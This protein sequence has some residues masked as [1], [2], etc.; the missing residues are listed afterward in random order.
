MQIAPTS[1]V[2]LR[3]A[4]VPL[5]YDA[6]E[7][8]PQSVVG[9]K[10][11]GAAAALQLVPGAVDVPNAHRLGVAVAAAAAAP[12]DRCAAEELPR[13]RVCAARHVMRRRRRQERDRPL[14]VVL[15]RGRHA[16]SAVLQT[17]MTCCKLLAQVIKSDALGC[18]IILR[19]APKN[20]VKHVPPSMRV[21]TCSKRIDEELTSNCLW[22][23]CRL[24][25]TCTK[26]I[27]AAGKNP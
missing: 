10:A 9:H 23:T 25:Y 21:W 14:A 2:A 11:H 18:E 17:V 13:G 24:S 6:I 27:K 20:V 16:I 12:G 8:F 5:L 19:F 7:A 1:C 4:L 22:Q 3:V 26:H 15:R